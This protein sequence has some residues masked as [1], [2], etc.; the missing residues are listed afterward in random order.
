LTNAA[1]YSEPCTEIVVS[2]V[3]HQRKVLFS[4]VDQGMGM[5]PDKLASLFDRDG[6]NND[7]GSRGG[8]GLGL[9]IVRSLVRLHG[10]EV[11][12]YSDGPG[13]GSR[14][15]GELPCADG[16]AGRTPLPDAKLTGWRE[17]A[18]AAGATATAGSCLRPHNTSGRGS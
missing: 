7:A 6:S 8:L 14:F 18:I 2:A 15:V 1:K 4:V 3:R 12:A 16:D 9:V 17:T 13:L 11:H 5:T 10:G